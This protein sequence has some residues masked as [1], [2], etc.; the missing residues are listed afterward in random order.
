MPTGWPCPLQKLLHG[1]LGD[2]C[3]TSITVVCCAGAQI[4]AENEDDGGVL[5]FLPGQDD[6][7]SLQVLLEENLPL[8][9][10]NC[11]GGAL[12]YTSQSDATASE[13]PAPMGE[14]DA[15]PLTV[16]VE[17]DFVIRPLYAALPPDEQ[18]KVF[19]PAPRGVRKFV[20]A[21]NIAETSVTITGIKYGAPSIQLP[22]ALLVSAVVIIG[23]ICFDVFVSTGSCGHWLCEDPIH[24]GEYRSGDAQSVAHFEVPGEPTQRSSWPRVGGSMLPPVH[25]AVVHGPSRSFGAGDST[26]KH[27]AG[28]PPTEGSGCELTGRLPIRF[29]TDKSVATE[30]IRASLPIGGYR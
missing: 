25:R 6:I 21:T 20:L 17:R 24:N 8:I 10:S 27:S 12:H 18:V 4:H 14:G 16:T 28:P 22:L 5:V 30:S 7:E 26:H 11:G 23:S 13:G 3:A 9:E 29:S 19:A 2:H 1:F 15:V